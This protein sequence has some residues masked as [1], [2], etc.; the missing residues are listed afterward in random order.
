MSK[1]KHQV[2]RQ[3]KVSYTDNRFFKH[4]QRWPSKTYQT[5]GPNSTFREI[6]IFI[7]L[8]TEFILIKPN[9]KL[10]DNITPSCLSKTIH[11]FSVRKLISKA[12]FYTRQISE[13][14]A[15]S[16]SWWLRGTLSLQFIIHL[17]ATMLL[18]I[19]TLIQKTT[20]KFCSLE[21]Y[22]LYESLRRTSNGKRI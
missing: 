22:A 9:C 10:K 20:L 21:N 15:P 11:K 12:S 16:P 19:T 3:T 18:A 5:P 6:N 13:S 14:P 8:N 2:L 1:Q 7:F 17:Q 4:A